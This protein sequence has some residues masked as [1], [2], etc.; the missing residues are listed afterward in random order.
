LFCRY[1]ADRPRVVW[2]LVA[3]ACVG[4]LHAVWFRF[5]WSLLAD[6][7]RLGLLVPT[8]WAGLILLRALFGFMESVFRRPAVVLVPA[9]VAALVVTVLLFV[10]LPR[11]PEPLPPVH[12]VRAYVALPRSG[13]VLLVGGD[14]AHLFSAAHTIEPVPDDVDVTSVR[15][16]M[17]S[18]AWMGI[19]GIA[20]DVF[21]L[22]DGAL[23][24][25]TIEDSLLALD[26]VV[27]QATTIHGASAELHQSRRVLEFGRNAV[28]ILPE[29]GHGHG[30]EAFSSQT[31]L[32]S[33]VPVPLRDSWVLFPRDTVDSYVVVDSHGHRAAGRARAS[34]RELVSLVYQPHEWSGDKWSRF[35]L[36]PR[37]LVG[38]CATTAVATLLAAYALATSRWSASRSRSPG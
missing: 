28:A 20:P 15:A 23:T 35:A 8:L 7:L 1:D 12:G 11:P 33:F 10:T 4:E 13:G 14:E 5:D 24:P 32:A 26:H 22:G 37:R 27:T 25:V 31:Q 18:A 2:L 36:G 3:L 19:P 30:R 17:Q 6:S 38:A 21:E 16:A 34:F 9:A 29:P